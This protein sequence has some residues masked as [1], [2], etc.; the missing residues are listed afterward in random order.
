MSDS[1]NAIS[2]DETIAVELDFEKMTWSSSADEPL[3]EFPFVAAF[4]GKRYEIYS[5]GTFDEVEPD[6]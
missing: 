4:D 3:G 6:S 1:V 5:D 2:G